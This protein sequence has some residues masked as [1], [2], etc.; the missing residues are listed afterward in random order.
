LAEG[1]GIQCIG[2][3]GVMQA[4]ANRGLLD[5]SETIK[6]LRDTNMRLPQRFQ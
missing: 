6:R 1:N 5:F 4:A 3:L 2:T